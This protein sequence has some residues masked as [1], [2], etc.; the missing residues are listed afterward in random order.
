MNASMPVFRVVLF[1]LG[2]LP[3]A[4]LT[5]GTL[6]ALASDADGVVALAVEVQSTSKDIAESRA[7]SVAKERLI[8]YFRD[9]FIKSQ[10][11]E[12]AFGPM[13]WADISADVIDSIRISRD[14]KW[15]QVHYKDK[16]YAFSGKIWGIYAEVAV[17]KTTGEAK[18]VYLEIEE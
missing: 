15:E 12:D 4:P 10:E 1:F 14:P 6:G 11:F 8:A 7:L 2:A 5:A 9:E 16:Y 18:N 17:D 3:M 13:E